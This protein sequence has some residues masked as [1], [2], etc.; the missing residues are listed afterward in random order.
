[1]YRTHHTN[2]S[3]NIFEPTGKVIDIKAYPKIFGLLNE[4]VILTKF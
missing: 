4:Y 1:M 2:S 3:K